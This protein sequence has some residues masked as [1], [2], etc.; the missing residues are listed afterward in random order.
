M[1]NGKRFVFLLLA[2]LLNSAVLAA[3]QNA[4]ST[5]S[6]SPASRIYLDV[7]VTPNSG[8]PVANL[9]QQDFVILD[10][11]TPRHATSFKAF[12]GT[13]E[14]IEVVLVIDAVNTSYQNLSYEREEID[15]FLRANGGRLPQ[16]MA[17][18]FFTD[19][20]TQFQQGF[21]TDGNALSASLDQQVIGLRTIRRS[22]QSSASERVELSMKALGEIASH[23]AGRPGRKLIFW[24]SPGW[25]LLSGP[26]IELTSKQQDQLFATIVGLSDQLREARITLYSID[27]LGSGEGVGR[28]FYYQEFLKGVSKASQVAVGDLSLQVLATQ[29]G[30]LAL[31]SSNDVVSMLQKCLADTEAYYA[32]S[33]DPPPA[34]HRDEYHGLEIRLSKPGLTA[35]TRQGYYAQP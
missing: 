9:Q 6:P 1:S 3:P 2:L 31:S 29:S 27:P 13:Q 4:Q 19:T 21:S 18:A 11:K 7:V 8:P 23:E 16:P 28:I 20:S 12:G 10:N 34:D 17:L 5:P 22:S 15:K 32:I 30:G 33:F 25:P 35:R 14:P 26:R 24:V